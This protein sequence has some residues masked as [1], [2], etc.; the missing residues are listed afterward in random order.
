MD[1]EKFAVYVVMVDDSEEADERL[2][3]S[4]HL[5]TRIAGNLTWPE[6]EDVMDDMEVV[7]N[8]RAE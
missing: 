3:A 1:D 7:N 2:A 5:L 6:A 8:E 4:V